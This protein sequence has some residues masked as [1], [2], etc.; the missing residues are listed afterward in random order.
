MYY[1]APEI[2]TMAIAAGF[3]GDPLITMIATAIG[4]SGGNAAARGDTTLMDAKWGPSIGLTQIRSLNAERGRG[5]TRDEL[6]NLDPWTNLRHAF[7]IS[8][9][10]KNFQPWSVFTSGKYKAHLAVARAAAAA[11]AKDVK[12]S[13]GAIGGGPEATRTTVDMP[14]IVG[15]I[16]GVSDAISGV[17]KSVQ[18]VGDFATKLTWLALPSS[19]VRITSAGFGIAFIFIGITML[20]REVRNG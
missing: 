2:A 15:A 16:R 8:G 1:T 14:D 7:E 11:P 17:G 5:T 20:G 19:W 4:E 18:H 3:R 9:Q 6:A 10:G 13:T 12:G